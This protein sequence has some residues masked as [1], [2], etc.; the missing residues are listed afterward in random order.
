L[1]TVKIGDKIISLERARSLIER[2]FHLRQSG[3][4]QQEVASMLGVERSFISH[5]EGLGEIRRSKQIALIGFGIGNTSEVEEVGRNLGL[6]YIRLFGKQA[7]MEEIL[8]ALNW[9]QGVDFIVF[10]G[11]DSEITLFEKIINKKILGI[12]TS[13]DNRL[14]DTEKLRETLKGLA[15]KRTRRAYRSAKRGERQ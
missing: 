13:G 11:R 1:K 12:S 3:S 4:T 14:V 6:D 5:L 2:I 15:E 10:M 8:G 9:V 7:S